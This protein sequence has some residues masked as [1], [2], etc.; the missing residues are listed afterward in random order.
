MAA[1]RGTEPWRWDL[2]P[3]RSCPLTRFRGVLL[4]PLGHATAEE[5]TGAQAG[6]RIGCGTASSRST[7]PSRQDHARQTC[8]PEIHNGSRCALF[9][10]MI[11]VSAAVAGAVAVRP[12]R[13]AAMRLEEVP[14]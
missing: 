2:N 1:L 8:A 11:L 9:E 4:R 7:A 10:S 3:R 5:S 12:P 6:D 14:K 13:S